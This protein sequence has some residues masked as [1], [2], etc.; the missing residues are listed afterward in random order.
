MEF[1]TTYHIYTD[2][3]KCL[4]AYFAKRLTNC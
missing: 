2:S 4:A 1:K 3:R